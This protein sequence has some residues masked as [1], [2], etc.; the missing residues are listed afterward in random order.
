[1]LTRTF[2]FSNCLCEALIFVPMR[3]VLTRS[4]PQPHFF[5]SKR[6]HGTLT[7]V[8]MSNVLRFAIGVGREHLCSPPPSEPDGRFSRIRL[9]RRWLSR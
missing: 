1:M 5:L 3:K 8:R 9:S 6:R 7:V 4:H 2:F